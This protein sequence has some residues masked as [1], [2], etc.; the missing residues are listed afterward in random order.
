MYYNYRYA[1]SML[2]SFP[3][4]VPRA[5]IVLSRILFPH[6]GV[7]L[8]STAWRTIIRWRTSDLDDV[9]S[10]WIERPISLLYSGFSG[11]NISTWAAAM[12]DCRW[13]SRNLNSTGAMF[14]YSLTSSTE[15]FTTGSLVQLLF[16]EPRLRFYSHL[17]GDQAV[18]RRWFI[19]DDNP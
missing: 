16:T 10:N 18:L 2:R 6:L 15:L 7:W 11:S 14:G 12:V 19:I 9:V 4:K 5:V 3:V 8:T 17:S 1:F 13:W